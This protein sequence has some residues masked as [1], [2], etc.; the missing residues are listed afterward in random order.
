MSYISK[1]LSTKIEKVLKDYLFQTTEKVRQRAEK[2]YGKRVIGKVRGRPEDEEISIDKVG[3]DILE[4]LLEKYKLPV[5]VFFEHRVLG[6]RKPEFFGA[7]DP[8]D[9]SKLFQR[10]FEHMWYTALSFYRID[11]EPIATG[12]ADILNE[13]FYLNLSK[14]NYL[15][16][17][18]DGQKTRIFPLREKD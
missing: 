4:R 3:E 13:K 18:K 15:F 2:G 16:S 14:E 5:L 9:G 17:L 6:K 7:L 11:G 8:F 10:G 1:S 12:I